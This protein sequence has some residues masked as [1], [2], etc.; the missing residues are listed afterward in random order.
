MVKDEIVKGEQDYL[1]AL[2]DAAD[3][4]RKGFIAL[5]ILSLVLGIIGLFMSVAVTIAS[6]IIFGIFAVIAGILFFVGAFSQDGTGSK[7]M[8]LLVGVLYIIGGA[9]MVAYPTMSAVSITLVMAILLMIIGVVRIIS[10]F[11][12]RQESSAWIMVVA[13]GV[14]GLI[15]GALVYSG[16]P[17]SGV[18]VI[19]MFVSIEFIVQGITILAISSAAK[20]VKKTI[21]E[22]VEA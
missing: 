18:W 21:K 13:N 15:L 8:M 2:K 22:S 6:T 17:E 3:K 10:G 5:G 20:K 11:M 4:H 16:W 12:M 9:V 14:M 7:I 19:G 1:K